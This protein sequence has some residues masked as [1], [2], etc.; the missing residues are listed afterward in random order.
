MGEELEEELLEATEH[1]KALHFKEGQY[2]FKEKL[3]FSDVFQTIKGKE[4]RYTKNKKTFKKGYKAT[5]E[6][7]DHDGYYTV[8]R[9]TKN[10][11]KVY[12][13]PSDEFDRFVKARLISKT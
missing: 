5:V 12:R 6:R 11:K 4:T 1:H 10:G 8:T 7:S 9:K 2:R 3:S 13:I